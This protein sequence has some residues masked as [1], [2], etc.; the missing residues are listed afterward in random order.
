MAKIKSSSLGL[1]S[2]KIGNVVTYITR[3]KNIVRI[4]T[5]TV[6]NPNTNKQQ[7][8]R[9]RFA[10]LGKLSSDFLGAI[11][12]GFAYRA[13]QRRNFPANNF[14]MANWE[15]VSASSAD[16]VTVDYASMKLAAGPLSEVE[17]GTPDWGAQEHLTI[18]VP[19]TDN[20]GAPRTDAND[21]VY[22][23]AYVPELGQGVLS[24]ASTR[25]TASVSIT[26]PTSWNGMTAHLWG[27]TVGQGSATAGTVSDSV[28]IGNGEVA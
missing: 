25:S 21:E 24:T 13:K 2:G 14:M 5:D 1:F 18:A 26:V 10:A 15:A 3:G 16:D 22:I 9:A 12:L 19:F 4:Y 8:V 20:T 28:Y 11:D 17:F 7:L 27:F 23:F 6:A